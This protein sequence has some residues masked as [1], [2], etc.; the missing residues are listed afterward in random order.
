M[1]V[2]RS[3][4]PNDMVRLENPHFTEYITWTKYAE[5]LAASTNERDILMCK[6]RSTHDPTTRRVRATDI[7]TNSLTSDVDV[8]VSVATHSDV[9]SL[10]W[11]LETKYDE[12]VRL[13]VNFYPG[14]VG[15]PPAEYD[16]HDATRLLIMKAMS[17]DPTLNDGLFVRS[18]P[19]KWRQALALKTRHEKDREGTHA[20]LY[21]KIFEHLHSDIQF[22]STETLLTWKF[23]LPDGYA[24]PHTL[25][26]LTGG[27][28]DRAHSTMAFLENAI[29]LRYHDKLVQKP[30][31]I[32]RMLMA[33]KNSDLLGRIGDMLS[34]REM[35]DL[36][37]NLAEFYHNLSRHRGKEF[38]KGSDEYV[39]LTSFVN[40]FCV[41]FMQVLVEPSQEA[42]DIGSIAYKVLLSSYK[43]RPSIH[44]LVKSFVHALK[45]RTGLT[46]SA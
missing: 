3:I 28:V 44:S 46:P 33:L 38:E 36:W 12:M 22:P 30:K 37:I 18:L 29:C 11:A 42:C 27:P 23:L 20:H 32:K 15:R 8:T 45:E 39:N 43:N 24:L 34:Q 4:G 2:L 6:I 5:L 7:G 13:D 17:L 40:K 41:L 9:Q 25:T 26:A 35:I 16:S 21:A 31:Y 14:I 19:N 1:A 10:E